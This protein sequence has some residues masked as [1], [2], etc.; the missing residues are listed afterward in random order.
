[1]RYADRGSGDSVVLLLHGFAGDLDNWMFNLGALAD[2][3]RVLALDLPAPKQ[4]LIRRFPEW[5]N[6]SASF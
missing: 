1:M 2:K 4:L 5:Q 3:H 6:L